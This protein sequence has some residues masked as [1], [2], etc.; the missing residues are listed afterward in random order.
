MGVRKIVSEMERQEK[1]FCQPCP[2]FTLGE[3]LFPSEELG[4]LQMS[5]VTQ[6]MEF[7]RFQEAK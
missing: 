7:A 2:L 6:E 1:P 3:K 5:A 4:H